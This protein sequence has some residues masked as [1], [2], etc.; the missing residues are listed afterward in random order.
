MQN[1]LPAVLMILGFMSLVVGGLLAPPGVYRT[2]QLA[3][4]LKIITEHKSGWLATN[5]LG[6]LGVISTAAGFVLF[7]SLLWTRQSKPLLVAGA[8]LLV[9][10]AAAIAF[11]SYRRAT[12]PAVQL[13]AVS[14]LDQ[15]GFYTLLL[16]IFIFGFIFLQAGYPAWLGYVSI[17]STVVL[18]LGATF[19]NL[20]I[21]E[22]AFL[23]PLIASIVIWRNG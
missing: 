14:S 3:D 19:S 12:D 2:T 9:V 16:G 21:A 17:G 13:A 15:V 11:Q 20:A 18:G 1:K 5:A 23:I 4:R 7:S 10:S 8:A 6:A 22:L